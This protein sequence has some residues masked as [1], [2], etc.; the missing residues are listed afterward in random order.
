MCTWYKDLPGVPGYVIILSQEET[1]ANLSWKQM[2]Y[3]CG[4]VCTTY[5]PENQFGIEGFEPQVC[6]V[7]TDELLS[8]LTVD[9]QMAVFYHEGGHV[10]LG[11][12]EACKDTEASTVICHLQW[13]LDADAY[14]CQFTEPAIALSALNKA[15]YV[16]SGWLAKL[17]PTQTREFWHS[18]LLSEN[19]I[20]RRI[21]ALEARLTQ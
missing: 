1:D 5:I 2:L 14:A 11:H 10:A 16:V 3:S 9:E 7:A 12:G 15:I 17:A 21:E 20:S 13:E 4:G 19:R 8:Q 18:S 6:I